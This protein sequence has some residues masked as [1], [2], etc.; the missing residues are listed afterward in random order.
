MIFIAHA[1]TYLRGENMDNGFSDNNLGWEARILLEVAEPILASSDIRQALEQSESDA[2]MLRD[3]IVS[4]SAELICSSQT[5]TLDFV[6]SAAPLPFVGKWRSLIAAGIAVLVFLGIY[7]PTISPYILL[8]FIAAASAVII[9]HFIISGKRL[10]LEPTEAAKYVLGRE[11]VGPFLRRQINRILSDQEH[12]DVMRVT[13]APGLAELSDREQLVATD[14]MRRLAQL[15]ETMSSGS[16]GLSGPRGVGKTTLLRS[17]CDPSLGTVGDDS[18]PILASSQDLRILISAPVEY[19]TRDFILHLF[20]KFCETLL[21]ASHD[22][23]VV[24]KARPR[25]DKHQRKPSLIFLACL[26]IA[27][28]LALVSY[29]LLKPKHLP[30]L[31][32]SEEYLA[33]AVVSIIAGITII[34]RQVGKVSLGKFFDRNK[35]DI[36]NEANDWLTRIRYM[37]TL[38][39][40]YSGSI[41]MPLSAEIGATTT[42]QLA[43]LQLTLPE[44]VDRFRDFAPRAI[45]SRSSSIWRLNRARAREE[46]ELIARQRERRAQ[47]MHVISNSLDKWA[48]TYPL[49]KLAHLRETRFERDADLSHR[50]LEYLRRRRPSEPSPR[51]AIGIDEIDR[52]SADSAERFLND[53][54]AI[55][56]IPHCLYLVSV[57]NEA[58]AVFEQRVLHGRSA[59][60]S[61]FDEVV[62]ARELDFESC[63]HLLRQRIAGIPDALIAFCEIMS[64]GLPRDLIRMARDVVDACSKGEVE[65]ANLTFTILRAQIETLKRSLISEIDTSDIDRP[66]T[67]SIEYLI[68]SDWPGTTA[69][70][71]SKTIESEMNSVPLTGSFWAA[72]YLY[73]TTAEIFGPGLYKTINSL[74]QYNSKEASCVDR[75]AYARN[76]I[77]VN[78]E[79]AWQLISLFRAA[80][81]LRP[82]ERRK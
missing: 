60:D 8:L 3:L 12:S 2:D 34:W 72:L 51:I 80:R 47:I 49:A 62:R 54:K 24:N 79:A 48:L 55:F 50:A 81:D 36:M 33:A 30:S 66:A 78:D 27:L 35:P 16:I 59:F 64:G 57:S 25:S 6:E 56:G 20:E 65:I 22:V 31:T 17:F 29:A 10:P 68:Q 4:H 75:L 15:A 52:M 43:E 82:V 9:V 28:G 74:R 77:S 19:D 70:S 44:L 11:V 58:L 1:V 76:M 26:L 63:R 21:G 13:S 32:V 69:E 37:Q 42:R 23:T 38:T 41:R 45:T 14:T 18:K 73:A 39:T 67:S 46:V 7:Y 53:I 5:A 61:T 71:I 40:G